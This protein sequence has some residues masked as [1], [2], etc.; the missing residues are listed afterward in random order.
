MKDLEAVRIVLSN[1]N[2]K[3]ECLNI[4][5]MLQKIYTV[6]KLNFFLVNLTDR[7]MG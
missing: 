3:K 5:C 1:Y 4:T 2:N 7:Q 6:N